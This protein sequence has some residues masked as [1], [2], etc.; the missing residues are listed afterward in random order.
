MFAAGSDDEDAGS[1]FISTGL[2]DSTSCPLAGRELVC[3]GCG[4]VCEGVVEGW[5]DGEA[6]ARGEL[7]RQDDGSAEEGW[8]MADGGW[9]AREWRITAPDV[10]Q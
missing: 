4:A 1:V 10:L 7:F 5:S 8:R 6:M 3:C 9:Q 2:D